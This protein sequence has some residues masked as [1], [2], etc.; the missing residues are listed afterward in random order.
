MVVNGFI[1]RAEATAA[2]GNGV[3]FEVIKKAVTNS[4]SSSSSS[5]T[6]A[7]AAKQYSSSVKLRRRNKDEPASNC[8]ILHFRKFISNS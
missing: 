4:S 6:A 8:K 1:A 7:A 5:E 2:A 3:G